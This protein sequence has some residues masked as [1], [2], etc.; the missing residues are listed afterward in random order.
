MPGILS[1]SLAV[2][3][4]WLP[5]PQPAMSAAAAITVVAPSAADSAAGAGSAGRLGWV[6]WSLQAKRPSRAAAPAVQMC[7]ALIRSSLVELAAVR[8]HEMPHSPQRAVKP[9]ARLEY[10]GV[11][12]FTRCKEPGD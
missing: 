10:Q 1:I 11:D 4:D 9:A 12:G 3:A 5:E 6:G 2:A 8:R 7:F